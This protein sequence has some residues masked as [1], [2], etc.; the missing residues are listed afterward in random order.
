MSAAYLLLCELDLIQLL[1]VLLI[2]LLLQ[3]A[4]EGLL[5]LEVP[6]VL[7]GCVLLELH[8]GLRV[9]SCHYLLPKGIKNIH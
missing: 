7:L 6:W 5:L 4:D 9:Q 2:V 1:H 8:G 3:L